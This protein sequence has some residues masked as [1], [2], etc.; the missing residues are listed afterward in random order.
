MP[1]GRDELHAMYA[2]LERT[3]TVA[4]AYGDDVP[5]CVRLAGHRPSPFHVERRD[6]RHM[7][8]GGPTAGNGRHDEFFAGAHARLSA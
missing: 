4:V 6:R 1:C 2:W 3:W 5:R 7:T 8:A